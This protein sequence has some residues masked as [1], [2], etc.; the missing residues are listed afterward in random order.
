MVQTTYKDFD[1]T[2]NEDKEEWELREENLAEYSIKTLKN[3]IDKLIKN[4][5]E[6]FKII[7]LDYNKSNIEEYELT[8]KGTKLS[9]N[10]HEVFWMKN[11]SGKREKQSLQFFYA[12]TE[13]NRTIMQGIVKLK[14][15]ITIIHNKIK[16][17]EETL[18]PASF[19]LITK[20]EEVK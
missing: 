16:K 14:D 3:Q 8:N 11:Q 19:S 13:N 7:R 5:I 6:G 15:E 12:D 9:Y 2:F 10:E 17:C 18:E 1:I 20:T 4:K